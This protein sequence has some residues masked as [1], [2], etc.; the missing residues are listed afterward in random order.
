MATEP[1]IPDSEVRNRVNLSE[2]SD[3]EV[4]EKGEAVALLTAPRE[5]IEALCIGIAQIT[6]ARIDWSY[7]GGRAVVRCLGDAALVRSIFAM[8]MR[9]AASCLLD[10]SAT[11]METPNER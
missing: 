3:N 6:G 9:P 10:S 8:Y 11:I 7:F 5:V 1:T 2:R 4:Y